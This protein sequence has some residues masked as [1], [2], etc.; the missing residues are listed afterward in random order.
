MGHLQVSGDSHATLETSSGYVAALPSSFAC[1][2]TRTVFWLDEA[3][4]MLLLI[5][6]IDEMILEVDLRQRD[7]AGA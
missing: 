5:P 7:N 6:R 3:G 4:G 2:A 1:N